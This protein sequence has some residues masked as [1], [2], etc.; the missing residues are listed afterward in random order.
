MTKK[1]NTTKAKI[2]IK[3]RNYGKSSMLLAEIYREKLKSVEY[4]HSHDLRNLN[5]T[6]TQKHK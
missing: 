5:I 2:K 6:I 4:C 1:F 3:I